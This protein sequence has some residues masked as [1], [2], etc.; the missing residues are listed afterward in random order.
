MATE[1]R[2]QKRK[3]VQAQSQSIKKARYAGDQVVDNALPQ[4]AHSEG[5][6]S[7]NSEVED[8]AST[9]SENDS[10][11]DLVANTPL[12]PFS[13]KDSP[14][15]PSDLKTHLC[16]YPNCG[17]AF[18]RPAKLSLHILSHTKSR[19]FVCPHQPCTKD[20]Q[21][22]SHLKHHIK[23]AH[24]DVRD[25]V[26]GWE[27]CGKSFITATRLKRHHG[28]HEGREKF[29]CAVFGCGQ[30][31]R[32]HVTLQK[33]I[34]TVHEGRKAYECEQKDEDGIVCGQG[35]DTLGKLQAH[36]GRVHGGKRFWCS[37][38]TSDT[39]PQ[40]AEDDPAA[41]ST[42][43]ELQGHIKV[44]HPLRCDNCGQVCHSQ[45]DLKSHIEVRH[46][47]SILDERKT[48]VCPETD[49]GRA[50]TK[51]GNLNVHI[52]SAHKAKKY[53][54]GQVDLETLNKVEGWDGSD[55]CG[56]P[57]S[58]KGSLENHIRTVHLGMGKRRSQSTVEV[59]PVPANTQG[60]YDLNIM[61]LTGVGYE[62][63]SGRHIPCQVPDCQFRFSRAYDLQVHLELRHNLPVH[64]AKAWTSGMDGK[65]HHKVTDHGTSSNVFMHDV[66]PVA[67]QMLLP[68]GLDS[69]YEEGLPYG[70]RFWVGNDLDGVE[71]GND[72]WVKDQMEVQRHL[73]GKDAG[74]QGSNEAATTIDPSL[75]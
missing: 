11:D 14:R 12:T 16:T 50:F 20:F 2:S 26:C 40:L 38:C 32:K 63:Y 3:S 37:I 75:Q 69:M 49:C 41:F 66:D 71:N 48:H 27:G 23:S 73:D 36:E 61:K 5:P 68:Q 30:T 55:A 57:L 10:D 52:Q 8:C 70:G 33:H 7:S 17:K 44:Y 18:N 51:K 64:E 65:S 42:Y 67:P 13:P 43:A 24:S 62:Q 21:R 15:F 39:F 25:Y 28:A 47:K 58:T 4:D 31:F 74:A 22:Q 19:P 54:C 45:R 46:G 60:G 34:I 9:A 59:I 29:K 1:R 53:I 56:R 72:D 6:S 35:F